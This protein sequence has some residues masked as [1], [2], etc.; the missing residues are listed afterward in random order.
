LNHSQALA[1]FI[2]LSVAFVS[3]LNAPNPAQATGIHNF[4][5]AS[6]GTTST[7]KKKTTTSTTVT[8][9]TTTSQTTSSTQTT[10]QTTSITISPTVTLN[11]TS[12]GVGSTVQ[13]TGSDFSTSDTSCSLSGGAVGSQSCTLADGTLVGAFTVSSDTAGAYQITATGNPTGDTAS[14]SFILS[15][16]PPSITLNPT[17]ASPAATVQVSGSGFLTSDSS[18]YLSGTPVSYYSCSISSGTLTASFTVASIDAGTYTINAFGTPGG[19]SASA[20]FTV[21]SGTSP[22]I[23]LSTSSA[24]AGNTVDVSGSGFSA[25]DTNCYVSS[26]AMSTSSCSISNGIISAAFTV[27]DVAASDYTITV[28]GLPNADSAAATLVVGETGPQITL[29]PP[30]AEPGTVVD[31]S[32]SGFNVADYSCSLSGTPVTS[33]TCS[34]SDGT[35]TGSFTVANA[36][37]SAYTVTAI[38]SPEGDSASTTFSLGASSGSASITLN[39][40]SARIAATV[41]VTGTGFSP[42]DTSCTL[43]GAVVQT[44]SCTIS[45]GILTASF[46]VAS[47]SP[48]SYLLTATGSPESDYTSVYFTVLTSP[49]VTL[50]PATAPVGTS[51]QVSGTGFS[52][53]D[54]SCAL[55]GTGVTAQSC[56]ISNGALTGSFTVGTVSP[57]AYTVTAIGSP[58]EDSGSTTLNIVASTLTTSTISTASA[59]SDFSLTCPPSASVFQGQDVVVP[60]TL[61]SINGFS[62]SVTMTLVWVGASPSGVNL[63]IASPIALASDESTT[64][65]LGVSVTSSATTGTFA[66]QVGGTSGSLTHTLTITIVI[67]AVVEVTVTAVSLTTTTSSA[68]SSTSSSSSSSATQTTSSSILPVSCPISG[69]T[70]GSALA[71]VAQAMRSFRDQSI[72]KTRIGSDFMTLFN[73]WYYS[74]SPTLAAHLQ[75]H[76]TQLAVFRLTL[77]PLFGI[78]YASYYSYLLLSPV[79]TELGAAMAG[80][81]TASLIGLV[82]LTPASYLCSR[83]LRRRFRWSNLTPTRLCLWVAFSGVLT[84]FAYSTGQML[85]LSIAATNLVM[86]SLTL[87]CILGTAGLTRLEKYCVNI[88]GTRHVYCNLRRRFDNSTMAQLRSRLLLRN[89]R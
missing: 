47:I 60:I 66:L 8:T 16:I 78:L 43:S 21:G 63:S 2:V 70:Y 1:M 35:L 52:T 74:F 14:A 61:T 34:V 42:S 84:G 73:S 45:D 36:A 23:T 68:T 37:A 88:H 18:C 57:S 64:S 9:S 3:V 65:S 56:S 38:G 58:I 17:S 26:S 82:Y 13:V 51:V 12:A 69:A 24:I 5:P 59:L 55:S 31:V 54:S 30:S 49:T 44:Q 77:Y 39:P 32:G 41:S 33:E 89:T 19:D 67:Q 7:S 40:T 76:R 20:S 25:A 53:G 86:C 83:T 48:S 15:T 71:T 75:T 29:S 79:S 50:H 87:G 46:V 11:P 81:L 62:S 27:G 28:T 85:P 72:L 80:V 10:S 22:S 4:S 6:K